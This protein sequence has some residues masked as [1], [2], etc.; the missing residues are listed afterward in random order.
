MIN[1]T[2]KVCILSILVV[3]AN[4]TFGKR[5]INHVLGHQIHSLAKVSLPPQIKLAIKLVTW[6]WECMN[7]ALFIASPIW[8]ERFQ[9]RETANEKQ[10]QK[11][12]KVFES[13]FY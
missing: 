1:F 7:Y 10:N 12:Y 3:L 13:T 8:F 2:V 9:K 11:Y 4:K 6:R 5:R